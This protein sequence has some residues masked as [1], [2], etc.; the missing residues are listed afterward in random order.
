MV[1]LLRYLVRSFTHRLA[2]SLLLI[3][4]F[5]L[6][7]GATT[8]AFSVLDA[9]LFKPAPYR[10]AGQLAELW[11]TDADGT[12]YPGLET[13]RA[14]AVLARKDLIAAVERYDRRGMLLGGVTEPEVVGVASFT[15]GLLPLL[16]INPAEGRR[17]LPEDTL[18]G[19]APVAVVSQA[20][21]EKFL[22]GRSLRDGP[23]IRLD[24]RDYTVVGVMPVWFRFPQ[25]VVSVWLPL[26]PDRPAQRPDYVVRFRPELDHPSARRALT[27]FSA[28]LARGDSGKENWG[29]APF[30]LDEVSVNRD[31]RVSLWLLAA[32]VACVLLV[33]CANAAGLLLVQATARHRELLIRSA[34]GATR[35]RLVG[36]LLTESLGFV[37]LGALGGIGLAYLVVERLPAFMPEELSL[38]SNAPLAV[39]HRVLTFGIG[40]T[41]LTWAICAVGPALL[42]SRREESAIRVSRGGTGTVARNRARNGLVVV[43][44]ALALVLLALTSLFLRSFLRLATVDTGFAVHRL[45]ITDLALPSIH[46]PTV[47]RR[48]ELLGRLTSSLRAVPGVE[49]ASLTT[50]LPPAVNLT[51]SSGLQA[52]GSAPL[53]GAERVIPFSDV[54]PEFFATVGIPLVR[55]RGFLDGDAADSTHPVV[56]SQALAQ[57]LWPGQDPVGRRFRL[58]DGGRWRTVIGVAGNVRMMGPDDRQFPYGYYN[59]LVS[60]PTRQLSLAIATIGP[61]ADYLRTIRDVIRR[62]APDL[63]V[64]SLASGEDRFAEGAAKPRFVLLLLSLFAGLGV[65]LAAIGVYGVTAY[66]VLQR[67]REIGIRMALGAG[68]ETILGAFLR[69]GLGLA[70]QGAVFGGIGVVATSH[71]VAGLLYGVGPRDPVAL[72]LALVLLLLAG[73]VGVLVPARRATRVNPMVAMAPD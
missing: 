67:T 48:A 47:E 25:G 5:A 28:D 56:V 38:F 71:L 73:L 3:V 43:Q 15:A 19:A 29:V 57:A 22:A 34:L 2:V 32:A 42:A 7:I 53:A 30:F 63:P 72:A 45:V 24:D 33:A 55:G 49:R 10:D 66:A 6:A 60:R 70:A 46:F 69:E 58:D 17:I 41:L 23:I 62:V 16:G 37:V 4:T 21:R 1:A 51:I 39:D 13:R 50:G 11:N 52:D 65:L 64:L 14:E 40:V 59:P 36:Q 54:D 27:T 68:R 18:P 20:F 26:G 44:F 31:V 12:S 35:A 61:P 9:V 8:S